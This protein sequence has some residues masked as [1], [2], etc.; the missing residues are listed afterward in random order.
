LGADG[1]KSSFGHQP[2]FVPDIVANA[3]AIAM[4]QYHDLSMVGIGMIADIAKAQLL[5][6]GNLKQ[7]ESDWID[8][9]DKLITGKNKEEACRVFTSNLESRLAMLTP[10]AMLPVV[11]YAEI[12]HEFIL[13]TT[14]F[15][16]LLIHV[17]SLSTSEEFEDERTLGTLGLLKYAKKMDQDDIYIKY[18][19]QLASTQVLKGNYVEA[20]FTLKQ[21]TDT[22]K[23]ALN[24]RIPAISEYGYPPQSA[25]ERKEYL[26]LQMLEFF[27][28]GQA[29]ERAI[30]I[31]K[32][33]S[34]QY[35][36][37]VFDYDRLSEIMR[38]QAFLYQNIIH[39]E[40]L[41]NEYFRVSFYGKG[42]PKELEN[43][44]YIYRGSEWERI[45]SFCEWIQNKYPAAT[46]LRTSN[47]PS[48]Y[49]LNGNGQ[50]IQVT[51]VVPEPDL[52]QFIFQHG[53]LVT[54]PI[55]QYHE[56]NGVSA[57][58]FTR[59]FRKTVETRP[60]TSTSVKD[61]HADVAHMWTEKTILYTEQEM[62]WILTRTQVIRV[63]MTEMSPIQNAISI[64]KQ[65][66]KELYALERRYFGF[67]DPSQ[68]NCTPLTTALNSVL[69]SSM[70]GGVR[71]Y[72]DVFMSPNFLSFEPEQA[73]YSKQFSDVLE[74]QVLR[75]CG[76]QVC[77]PKCWDVASLSIRR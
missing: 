53:D 12:L 51:S 1:K 19:Y 49:I 11:P 66:T 61:E 68:A 23:W 28:M 74:E 67:K 70:S 56:H 38:H 16:D 24:V 10:S 39:K 20:A 44:E 76:T 47:P 14:E 26:Y 52:K 15:T 46:V 55:R 45:D 36:N 40:R 31:C 42:Q 17:R 43:K 77:R 33:L 50:F 37:V 27:E 2:R 54:L 72:K 21:Y 32:E 29:W 3:L 71:V 64:I 18:T 30:G 8:Q 59:P 34:H 60:P 65:K 6:H 63:K 73:R 62:P 5:M 4:T 7:I 9:L 48:D 22:L 58:S 35:E 69:N 41:Y 75:L 25:F 13:S 57:F